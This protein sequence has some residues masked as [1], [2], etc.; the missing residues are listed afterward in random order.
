[1]ICWHTVQCWVF[2]TNKSCNCPSSRKV[3]LK[4]KCAYLLW[5]LSP[6]NKSRISS[7]YSGN[8]MSMQW[9]HRRYSCL[10]KSQCLVVMT[11]CRNN[12]ICY[13]KRV[14][15]TGALTIEYFYC[16]LLDTTPWFQ[17]L[18]K[19]HTMFWHFWSRDQARGIRRVVF[20][21]TGTF[22]TLRIEQWPTLCR[23]H[24]HMYSFEWKFSYFDS[25]FII[26][27]CS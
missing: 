17:W 5:C 14:F 6:D 19:S 27:V 3:I 16:Y 20:A 8:I 25:N 10:Q 12:A 21:L 15:I 9:V 23:R 1:M 2:G 7:W 22:N 24:Y 13:I 18:T 11:I 26:E 4:D